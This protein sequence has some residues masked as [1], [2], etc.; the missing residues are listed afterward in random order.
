[1]AAQHF[2]KR[3]ETH[4]HG[5]LCELSEAVAIRLI[6]ITHRVFTVSTIN[7]INAVI[8]YY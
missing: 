2:R 7:N 5:F 8:I 3:N 6:E 1:M 4:R